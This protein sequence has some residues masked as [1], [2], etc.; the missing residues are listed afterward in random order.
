MIEFDRVSR[1]FGQ[2]D[3]LRNLNLQIDNGE[4]ALLTGHSG[5]GKSTLLRLLLLLDRPTGGQILVDGRS[6]EQIQGGAVGRYRRRFGVVFQ[7]HRLL[8]DRNVRDNVALPLEIAGFSPQ[9]AKRRVRAALDKVGLL[10]RERADPNGLSGGEQQ[11]VAIAR[12]VVAR[13]E[14]LIAD[15]PT[16]NLDPTLSAEIMTLFEAFNQVGVT[17]LVATHDVSLI[18]RSRHRLMTLLAGQLMQAEIA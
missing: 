5:A 7:E 18:A 11:R 15:E 1:R 12:A 3:A 16:G 13:P 14:F 6:T 4:M 17:V 8:F 10:A 2:Q 9:E